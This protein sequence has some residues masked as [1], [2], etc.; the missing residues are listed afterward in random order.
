MSWLL[1]ASEENKSSTKDQHWLRGDAFALIVAGRYDQ[2][3]YLYA[4]FDL[5]A[6]SDTVASTLISIFYHIADD[7]LHAEKL[8]RELPDTL[9]PLE[10]DTLK[11]LPHLNPVINEALRLHPALPSGG[12]RQTPPGG[13]TITGQYIPGNVVVAAPKYSLGRRKY[14]MPLYTSPF[15][16]KPVESCYE[17]P[18]DFVPERWYSQPQM[19][20]NDAGFAPF[21]T[22]QSLPRMPLIPSPLTHA[23]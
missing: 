2:F 14:L 19:I 8:R 6:N 17:R 1:Q 5:S 7:P 18:N 10:A 13:L 23:N 4:V 9:F 20:R 21:S 11:S 22:G 16:I 12:L 3:A 15:K